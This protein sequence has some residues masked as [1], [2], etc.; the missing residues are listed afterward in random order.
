MKRV[1][2]LASSCL[3]LVAATCVAGVAQ[4][5]GP[6]PGES[7][8]QSYRGSQSDN[9]AYQKVSPIK[10][11]DN[12]YYVG[13]G[14]V[15]VWLIPTSD[16]VI[17]ID[18]AQ[19]PLVDHVIDSIRKI[20]F[21]PKT[22]KYILLTH[23]HLDHFGGAGKIQALSGARVAALQEDWTLIEAAYRN[24]GRG[25]QDRGVRFTRD[26]VLREG[27]DL[28]L[29][30]TTLKVHK[31][32]GHTPGSA[33]FA[34]TVYDNGR[35]HKALVL[36]GPGQRNGVEGGAQFLESIRRL[37]R[38]FADV[39]VPV[40]VHSYLTT[41]PVPGGGTVFEPAQQLARRK[42]GSP[43]P[44]V[45]NAA[46]RR[47][48]DVAEA[49]AMKYLDEEKLKAVV[50][51][52]I[53]VPESTLTDLKQRLARARFADEFTGADWDYGTSLDYLRGLVAYWRD[54]YDWRAQERRLNQFSQFKTT[55][56]G[57]DVHFVHQRSKN[58]T[59]LPLLLLNGWPSSIVEYEKV[60]APLSEAFHVVI[61][62]MPG[63]GF[64]GKP[65]QRGYDVERIAGMWVQLM[66]RLGYTRYAVHGSDWG[67]NVASRVALKDAAHVAG[68]HMAGCPA[69]AAAGGAPASLAP[70]VAPERNRL[71]DA[72]HNLG[73]QELQS[74]KPQ[75]LGHA[76]SDSPVG[77][78]SW[79]VEKWYGW[80]DHDGDL[81]KAVT[82]DQLLTN[83]MI[84]WVTN[85]G[86]S[87]A[88]L[89]QEG[90]HMSGALGP[91]PFPRPETRI[92]TPTGCGAFP[93]QY[94]R[95][96]NP[97]SPNLEAARKAADTRF[98]V[99]HFTQAEH[100]G[101]FPALEQPELWMSDL[102]AFLAGR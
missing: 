25:N 5:A 57:I 45:D 78:A 33:S 8:S 73:Y 21:D 49:G 38:E 97:P 42:A 16:G 9:V 40:H 89:Y 77:V 30:A 35:P 68:L 10:V 48:L 67:S 64:S 55:I 27:Q 98:N 102:K 81:E 60:I 72:A 59:A 79:I 13:P 2:V 3:A 54:T 52:T 46:W 37:K 71:V 99:V 70:P 93:W 7:L 44:F 19:E 1:G 56:D 32:P 62:S 63:F 82:K 74:T 87:S 94:D 11:F 53:Q 18:T 85:S 39:E 92:L 96:A 36:G 50:P 14:S 41:Y 51:F 76:L 4:Q 65:R 91:T 17:L 26:V 61:P 75:T 84:Y 66:A 6:A 69:P 23:G 88:R 58:P 95:R 31:M 29:G 101:H 100:G 86:A 43:H 20:G 34:F 22:I 15:S 28:T 90:R 80:A 24:P 47:W 12:L 83:I